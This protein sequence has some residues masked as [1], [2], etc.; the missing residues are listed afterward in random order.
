[1]E[2]LQKPKTSKHA[3]NFGILLGV[4]SVAFSVILY[5][6]NKQ[7]EG[8]WFVGLISFAITTVIIGLAFSQFKKENH[9]WLSLSE[10]LKLGLGAALIAGLISAIYQ[11]VLTQ[12]IDPEYMNK[13]A[14]FQYQ[15]MIETNPDMTQEQL[16]MSVN[17]MKKFSSPYIV[18]PVTIIMSLFFGFIISMILGLI[19]KKQPP[20][21]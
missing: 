15:K 4:V 9:G 21:N 18:F 14:D 12:V 17:M 2:E 3:I 7:F 20:Q 10:A 16:D 6:L 13:L 8:G 11:L 19:M 1:M 5:V